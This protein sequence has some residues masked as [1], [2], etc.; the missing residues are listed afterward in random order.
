MSHLDQLEALMQE[1]A[2]FAATL[3]GMPV[4][5]ASRLAEERGYQVNVVPPNGALT[6]DLNPTRM[7]FNLDKDDLVRS[8]HA[9]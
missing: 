8:A 3:V 1:G 5:T 9:G 4:D 6:L 7:S 2:V